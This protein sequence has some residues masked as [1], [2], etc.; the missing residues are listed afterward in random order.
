MAVRRESELY[1]Q[2]DDVLLI[3]ATM[4]S[5]SNRDFNDLADQIN[6]LFWCGYARRPLTAELAT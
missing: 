1:V 6:G 2:Q 5:T 3:T 4:S